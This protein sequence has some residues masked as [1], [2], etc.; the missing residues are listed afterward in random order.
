M[1]K[2]FVCKVCGYIVEKEEPP[3]VCPACGFEGKIFEEYE[4]PLSK[5]RRKTLDL[6]IHPVMVHLPVAFVASLALISLIR[7]IGVL[8]NQ[9][10]LVGMLKVIVA[11]LPLVAIFA[12]MA[13]IFD[14]KIRFKRIDT[15]HLKKKLVLASFLILISIS[16]FVSQYLLDLN[17]STHKILVFVLS[18]LMLCFAL[19]LGLIGGRLRD[20]KVRG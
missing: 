17:P 19:I 16:L 4:S 3:G 13:G 11:V 2:L 7:V 10:E 14:A 18:V 1:K 8:P 9:I 5:K 15:P 20:S 6:H 12:A